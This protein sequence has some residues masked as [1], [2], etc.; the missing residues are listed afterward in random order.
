[1]TPLEIRVIDTRCGD[2]FVKKVGEQTAG[3][4]SGDSEQSPI[5]V[6]A[7]S[8]HALVRALVEVIGADAV[9]A[10]IPKERAWPP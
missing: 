3:I 8:M 1:M 6:S 4:H 2:Y 5:F 7:Q 10:A 9:R